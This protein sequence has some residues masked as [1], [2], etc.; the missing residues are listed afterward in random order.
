MRYT[1]TISKLRN[2]VSSSQ[3]CYWERS[4]FLTVTQR[5]RIHYR[6]CIVAGVS[7]IERQTRNNVYSVD[8]L[9]DKRL[10]NR[11]H[12]SRKIGYLAT[13]ITRTLAEILHGSTFSTVARDRW[14]TVH[15]VAL[16]QRVTY[17]GNEATEM[18]SMV[19][20]GQDR[21]PRVQWLLKCMYS[22]TGWTN[23]WEIKERIWV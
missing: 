14:T 1:W 11:W 5:L 18:G 15:R 7:R 9:V 23:V 2:S 8:G 3:A 13:A 4:I 17:V 22:Y 21:S 20:L 19:P 12:L 10:I 6:A 16:W